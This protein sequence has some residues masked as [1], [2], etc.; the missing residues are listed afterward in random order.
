MKT[1]R[2]EGETTRRDDGSRLTPAR[3]S[4]I[5]LLTDFGSTDYFV[6]AL[7]GIVLSINPRASLIDLTHEIPAHDVAAGAFTLVVSYRSFPEQTIHVAIV[8]PEVGSARRPIL[9]SAGEHFFVGPDNGIF[10]YVYESEPSYQTFHVTNEKYFRHPV[11]PTFHGRDIFAPVAAA[12]SLGAN[13]QEFG[14]EIN[15]PVRLASLRPIEQKNGKLKGRII[16]IDRFGNCITNFTRDHF[17]VGLERRSSVQI[18]GKTIRSFKRF[19]SENPN[20]SERL[21]AVWGSAGFLEIAAAN[22]SAAR[23]LG[24]KRGQPVILRSGKR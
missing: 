6:G 23:L 8:D 13:P 11:S 16:H 7:K 1:L 3:S 5:T 17:A 24:A 4:I 22:R 18:G 15:D 10:S 9:V 2:G 19:F 14:P 20:G 12:F 21:F